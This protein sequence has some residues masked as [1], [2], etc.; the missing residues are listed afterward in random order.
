MHYQYVLTSDWFK[1]DHKLKGLSE[2]RPYGSQ[3]TSLSEDL[4]A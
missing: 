2:P 3:H 4:V 1:S